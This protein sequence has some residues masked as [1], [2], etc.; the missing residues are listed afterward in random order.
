MGRHPDQGTV[1]NNG[2]NAH[3][4][5]GKLQGTYKIEETSLVLNSLK[6]IFIMHIVVAQG[7]DTADGYLLVS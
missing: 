3:R 2:D 5:K 7:A 6:S 4:L 1:G